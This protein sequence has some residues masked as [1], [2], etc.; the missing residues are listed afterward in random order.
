MR[1]A[2]FGAGGAGGY[3]GARLAR[4]GA[5]VTFIARGKHLD[6]MRKHGLR[7]DSVLGDFVLAPAQ[8]TDDPAQV[9][10]VDLVLLG[11]KAMQ[12]TPVLQALRPLVGPETTIVPLQ[13]GVEAAGQ[14]AE[15]FGIR[16]VVGGL[17]KVISFK[18]GAGHIRHAGADS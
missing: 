8:A 15:E 11:V 12:V 18:V 2:I 6:A 1:I 4:S 13:N 10:A 14:I 7:V 3:F 17:A 5:D 16:H 9:G